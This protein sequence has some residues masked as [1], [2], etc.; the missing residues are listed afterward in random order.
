MG[1]YYVDEE[2]KDTAKAMNENTKEEYSK[3]ISEDTWI[4]GKNLQQPLD[5]QEIT[6]LA[7]TDDK[8]K[9]IGDWTPRELAQQLAM[10]YGEKKG[11]LQHII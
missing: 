3:F 9:K 4:F 11:N 5:D 1:I 7:H 8:R 6:L 10:K 2:H